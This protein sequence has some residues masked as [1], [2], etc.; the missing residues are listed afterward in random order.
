MLK[1]MTDNGSQ[2]KANWTSNIK[3][4]LQECGLNQIIMVKPSDRTH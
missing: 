2:N 4:T 1:D 3:V